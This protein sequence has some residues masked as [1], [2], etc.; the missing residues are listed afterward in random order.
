MKNFSFI[1]A[2]L[3]SFQALAQNFDYDKKSGLV[4]V[5]GN[6]SFYFVFTGNAFNPMYRLENLQHEE[7]ALFK[8]VNLGQKWDPY[9]RKNQEILVYRVT[10]SNSLNTC[11]IPVDFPKSYVRNIVTYGLVKNN[12]IDP[13]AEERYV[14][15]HGGQLQINRQPQQVVVNVNNT[16]N[17]PTAPATETI[18]IRLEDIKI[19]SDK[20]Y[21]QSRLVG[22]YKI[23]TSGNLTTVT[24]YDAADNKVAVAT[25]TNNSDTDWEL[26]IP[27]QSTKTEV[28]YYED[29]TLNRLFQ[30]LLQKGL[31][32]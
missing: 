9:S 15:A 4:T 26:S 17:V 23:G 24:I 1:I 22:S 31:L 5:D 16:P 14:L 7:L 32:K 19:E 3:F 25:H 27:A 29:A 6:A 10:F 13:S 11:D 30:N 8:K 20:I 28:R 12:S 18:T 2:L 21:H